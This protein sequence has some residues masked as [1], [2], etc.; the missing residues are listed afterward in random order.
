MEQTTTITISRETWKK[1][2]GVKIRQNLNTMENTIFK[3]IK[4]IK[5]HKMEEELK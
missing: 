4:L 2:M 5:L 1:L 3:M